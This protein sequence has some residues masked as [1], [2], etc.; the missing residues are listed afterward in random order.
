[1]DEIDKQRLGAHVYEILQARFPEAQCELLYENP[2]ELLIATILSAQCTDDRVNM[3]TRSL[4]AELKTPEDYLSL[5]QVGLEERIKSLGLF[6]NK[7][8]NILAM[9]RVLL[10]EYEGEIPADLEELQK[11]P[12]VG[13]KTANVV[14]SN[15]FGIP[16]LAVDTHVFRVA[17]RLGLAQG[18]T[19]EKVEEELKQVFARA[20]WS[21]AH[22]LLIFHGRRIC[23][24]RKPQ[25]RLCPL[26]SECH[27]HKESHSRLEQNTKT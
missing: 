13:R 19:P 2:F 18:S 4:F 27:E 20:H 22:H 1:M 12:G 24:A 6:H 21:K 9:C 15:A 10:D 26:A 25:C 16:A 14:G 3:V 8:K 5:G 11:L 23:A 17:R 7:A